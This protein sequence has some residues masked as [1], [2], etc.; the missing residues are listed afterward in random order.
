MEYPSIL[1]PHASNTNINKLQ[2]IQNKALR[3]IYNT[4]WSD[5]TTNNSLHNRAKLETVKDR[6]FKLSNKSL[7]RIKDTV[8][9]EHGGNAIYVYSEYIIEEEPFFQPAG[10]LRNLYEKLELLN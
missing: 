5:F 1:L 9:D 8:L 6:L 10:K 7:E 2:I 3:F 4:H